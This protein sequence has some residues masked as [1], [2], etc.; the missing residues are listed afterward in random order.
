MLAV[1]NDDDVVVEPIRVNK[2]VHSKECT[3]RKKHNEVTQ[4]SMYKEVIT[5]V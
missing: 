5:L 3:Q 2:H 1:Q 4:C